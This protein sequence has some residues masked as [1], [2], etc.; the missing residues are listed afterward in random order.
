MTSE[1]LEKE[2]FVSCFDFFNILTITIFVTNPIENLHDLT[3]C[4][5]A[6]VISKE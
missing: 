4:C 6:L 1:K 3:Y 2:L 5:C